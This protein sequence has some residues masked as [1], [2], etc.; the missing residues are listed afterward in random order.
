MKP[1]RRTLV[2]GA[3]AIAAAMVLSFREGRRP[4]QAGGACCP[5]MQGM[6]L[7]PSNSG[8]TAESTNVRPCLT[9][10]EGITNHQR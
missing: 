4:T 10:G 6:N 8:T 3:A 1:D 5:L 7:L 9:S 2:I